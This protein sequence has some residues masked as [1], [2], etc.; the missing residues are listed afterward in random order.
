MHT[1]STLTSVGAK[2]NLGDL[3]GIVEE[4]IF[5][6]SDRSVFSFNRENRPLNKVGRLYS[7]HHLTQINFKNQ[8]F[9]DPS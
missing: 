1:K 9:V 4:G 8:F 3:S 5:D 2:F 6:E 7:R